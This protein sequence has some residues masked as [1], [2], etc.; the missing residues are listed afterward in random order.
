MLAL[1]PLSSKVTGFKSFPATSDIFFPVAVEPVK[2]ILL[3]PVWVQR[4]GPIWSPLRACATPGGNTLWNN[5]I[6]LRIEYGVKGD[7]LMIMQFPV[8][9]AAASFPIART[10]G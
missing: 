5:S 10:R 2:V 7:G 6:T 3:M 9:K 8:I 1:L 4:A